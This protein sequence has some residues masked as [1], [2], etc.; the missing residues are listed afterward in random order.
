MEF[1]GKCILQ[2]RMSG[3]YT[4]G[5]YVM[6]WSDGFQLIYRGQ[7]LVFICNAYCDRGAQ[8]TESQSGKYCTIRE[9]NQ[10]SGVRKGL[11]A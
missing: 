2:V 9:S 11:Y 8:R 4:I 5:S 6:T 7:V 3:V 10:A 1:Y